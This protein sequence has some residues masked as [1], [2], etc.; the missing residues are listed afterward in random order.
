MAP[1]SLLARARLRLARSAGRFARADEGATAVEFALVAIPFL[2]LLFAIIE[3]GLVFL[4]SI[5]LENAVID[6]GRTIRTGQVQ[7]AGT[8]ATAFKT[9]VCDRM[10]WLGSK[11]S[12]ALQVDVST[13]TDYSTGKTTAV[14]TTVPTT[15]NWNPGASGSIVLIRAY[16]T[17]PLITP[18]MNTGL[19][20]SNGNR[21]IYAATSFT[22]EPYEQ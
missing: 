4:V 20:S 21:I 19:Q 22:N 14:N 18:M 6:A 3:L 8:G 5:T 9:A 7:T 17:W 12:T 15:M 10:S 16:Y 1:R 11:C 13:F 2:M